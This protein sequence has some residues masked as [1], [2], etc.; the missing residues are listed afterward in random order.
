MKNRALI[1]FHMR[2][3][4]VRVTSTTTTT[5]HHAHIIFC[6]LQH[7]YHFHQKV[8]PDICCSYFLFFLIYI[9][10]MVASSYV[11][12]FNNNTG[13]R[14]LFETQTQPIYY[15][16]NWKPSI[17]TQ[18]K[19]FF[20]FCI[21]NTNENQKDQKRNK[22]YIHRLKMNICYKTAPEST[23]CGYVYTIIYKCVNLNN[24]FPTKRCF[25]SASKI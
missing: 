15:R 11:H 8:S 9:G 2:H 3:C 21:K 1:N 22:E 23:Y 5:S 20:S 4:R 14:A 25:T 10:T 17:H 12:L 19:Y 16:T 13:F 18:K 6:A 24:N 7:I